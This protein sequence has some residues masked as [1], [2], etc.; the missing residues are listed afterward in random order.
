MTES[1]IAFLVTLLRT[2]RPTKAE[3]RNS[4]RETETRDNG[5]GKA[6][7][8]VGKSLSFNITRTRSVPLVGQQHYSRGG[9]RRGEKRREET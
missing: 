1:E 6:I 7:R 4:G 9:R 3:G 8:L 2:D 5:M